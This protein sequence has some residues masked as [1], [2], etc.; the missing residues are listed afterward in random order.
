MVSVHAVR[1]RAAGF[2]NVK[3]IA[4]VLI[5]KV[6]RLTLGMGS[7]GVSEV[8]TRAGGRVNGAGLTMG[9]VAGSGLLGRRLVSA[10]PPLTLHSGSKHP[11][12]CHF[13]PRP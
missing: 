4:L 11:L 6:H 13:H 9:S 1:K 7:Y 8:G 2:S 12:T 5:D 3:S 10:N